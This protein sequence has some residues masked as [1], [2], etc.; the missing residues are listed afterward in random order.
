MI[1]KSF[2]KVFL[3]VI[4]GF[5]EHFGLNKIYSRFFIILML[6]LCPFKI[7]LLIMIAYLIAG[8]IMGEPQISS[9]D[10]TL[11]KNRKL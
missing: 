8:C 10:A 7:S 9:F 5:S 11:D 4:S 6:L 1:K 3:G 2:D